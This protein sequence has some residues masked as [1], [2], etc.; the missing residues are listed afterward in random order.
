MK[1]NGLLKW[2]MIPI[3]LLLVFVGVSL[4]SAGD[5]PTGDARDPEPFPTGVRYMGGANGEPHQLGRHSQADH[6]G[7]RNGANW[8][9]IGPPGKNPQGQQLKPQAEATERDQKQADRLSSREQ[10]ICHRQ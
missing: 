8:V 10:E 7:K 4:F 2:L 6:N 5:Q 1:S 9:E 3:V